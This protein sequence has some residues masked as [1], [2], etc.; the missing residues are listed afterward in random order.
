MVKNKEKIK[1][2]SAVSGAY[3]ITVKVKILNVVGGFA[4]L[5]NSIADVS[6][7]VAEVSLLYSDFHSTIR[8][9]TINTSSEEDSAQVV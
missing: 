7:S 5:L 9:I 6:A 3:S 4:N 8:A 2:G 1:R